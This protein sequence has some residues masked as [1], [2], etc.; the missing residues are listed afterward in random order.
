MHLGSGLK[1]LRITFHQ[2]QMSW[3][4]KCYV[5]NNIKGT[6]DD[7]MW[8]EDHEENSSSNHERVGSD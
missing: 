1:L 2:N 4:S 6:E 3:V 8:K 7:V 5:S